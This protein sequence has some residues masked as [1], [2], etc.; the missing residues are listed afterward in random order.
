MVQVRDLG[1]TP[2]DVNLGANLT[3]LCLY[4]RQADG[5]VSHVR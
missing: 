2:A 4:F 3:R 5:F 1:E